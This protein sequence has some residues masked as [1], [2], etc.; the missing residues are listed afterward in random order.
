LFALGAVRALLL[1]VVLSVSGLV[2]ERAGLG[3]RAG[4]C[5]HGKAKQPIG[6]Y[7]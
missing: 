5:E 3:D 7:L 4:R 2:D 1:P 6:E